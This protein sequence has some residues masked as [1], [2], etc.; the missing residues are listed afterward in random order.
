M[1]C[2]KKWVDLLADLPGISYTWGEESA[3]KQAVAS[4]M[5]VFA[6]TVIDQRVAPARR[7][8]QPF[9]VFITG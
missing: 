1:D 2:C 5:I 8:S 6:W 7:L 3:C 9:G 4:R